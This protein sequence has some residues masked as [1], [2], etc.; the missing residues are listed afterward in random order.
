MRQA[1]SKCSVIENF[2]YISALVL[3][4]IVAFRKLP[5]TCM[6]PQIIVSVRKHIF[7]FW[8]LI[9]EGFDDTRPSSWV[10]AIIDTAKV[11]EQA[12]CK[13]NLCTLGGLGLI[14]T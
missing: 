3:E 1:A 13:T 12:G 8:V 9:E 5:Y 2:T 4:L 14:F 6:M 11:R 7:W 10:G